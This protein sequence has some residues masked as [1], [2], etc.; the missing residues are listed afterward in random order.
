MMTTKSVPVALRTRSAYGCRTS[1][2]SR[3]VDGRVHHGGRGG[4]RERDREHLSARVGPA[5]CRASMQARRRPADDDDDQ[6][7]QL[8]HE[9]LP[10]D[11]RRERRASR[12]LHDA[13]GVRRAA[14]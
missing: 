7:E 4:D 9:H 12:I 6:H 1:R 11:G 8:Q 14:L 2:G 3:L 13:A 10:C 5:S